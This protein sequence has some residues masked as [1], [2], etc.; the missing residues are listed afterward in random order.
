LINGSSIAQPVE[1]PGATVIDTELDLGSGAGLEMQLY[2]TPEAGVNNYVVDHLQPTIYGINYGDPYYT[3]ASSPASSSGLDSA[4]GGTVLMDDFFSNTDS[5][6]MNQFYEALQIDSFGFIPALSALG[7]SMDNWYT[8][9]NTI[10]VSDTPF[11]A[12]YS[13]EENQRHLTL[14]DEGFDFVYQE[15]VN[16]F[17][18]T[19]IEDSEL[20]MI[21]LEQNPVE[22]QIR[23][24]LNGVKVE[25][26]QLDLYGLEGKMLWS[27]EYKHPGEE[28]VIPS[29]G[30]KGI[31]VVKIASGNIAAYYKIIVE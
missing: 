14:T 27:R 28:L 22:D 13:S 29:P 17:N 21:R 6:I 10:D 26:L 24:S 7:V 16:H 5:D 15:A 12:I 2:F 3:Y 8:P 4:P 30:D 18:I 11:D 25:S 9:L 1:V 20:Q 19:G 31:Y 23:F